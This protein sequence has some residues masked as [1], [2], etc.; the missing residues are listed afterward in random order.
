MPN[1]RVPMSPAYLPVSDPDEREA[2]RQTASLAALAATLLLVVVSLFLVG[3]L[4]AEANFQDC[5]LAGHAAC[6]IESAP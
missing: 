3:K 1:T 2:N 4:R 5:V 6:A